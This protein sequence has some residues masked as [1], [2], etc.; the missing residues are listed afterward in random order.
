MKVIERN[1]L[2]LKYIIITHAHIDHMLSM[3]EIKQKTGASILIHE[4]EKELLQDCLGARLI[5]KSYQLKEDDRFLRDGDIVKTG[6]LELEIIHTPG[7]TKG[8][9]CVKMGNIIFSG[10]TLL[11]M[12]AGKPDNIYGSE[13]ELKNS[14][15]KLMKFDD[16]VVLY[17]GHGEPTSIGQERRNNPF[18]LN[19]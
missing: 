4:N 13:S 19:K 17:P 1:G 11:K 16:A 12:S 2:S 7:H 9:V 10:D 15:G 14:I 18:V 6:D 3:D 8:C 5:D